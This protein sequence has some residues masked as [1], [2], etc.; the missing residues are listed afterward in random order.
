[1]IVDDRKILVAIATIEV[2]DSH[3]NGTVANGDWCR[4]RYE[5]SPKAVAQYHRDGAIAG[6]GHA[7]AVGDCQILNA[8]AIEVAHGHGERPPSYREVSRG[9]ERHRLGVR[10]VQPR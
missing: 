6:V 3:G 4:L 7:C 10:G 8:I 2:A 9:N 1:V 5:R